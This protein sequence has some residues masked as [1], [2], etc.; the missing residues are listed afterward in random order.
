MRGFSASGQT[1]HEIASL[2][3]YPTAQIFGG[4]SVPG[5][6]RAR[7][8]T[9]PLTKKLRNLRTG[10][11]QGGFRALREKSCELWREGPKRTR[12]R[13]M[14]YSLARAKLAARALAPDK[15]CRTLWREHFRAKK[16]REL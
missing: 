16:A 14:L 8:G 13:D 15:I 12:A 6:R 10:V 7:L 4:S 5:E 1:I 2:G 3:K 11:K 9:K